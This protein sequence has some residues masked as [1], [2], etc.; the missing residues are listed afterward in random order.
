MPPDGLPPNSSAVAHTGLVPVA[1]QPAVDLGLVVLG[2]FR[3]VRG[4]PASPAPS[5][6]PAFP[7]SLWAEERRCCMHAGALEDVG[8]DLSSFVG[9]GVY[10]PTSHRPALSALRLCQFG[11]E[12]TAAEA[13]VRRR[14]LQQ[15]RLELLECVLPGR[16]RSLRVRDVG[17]D[18]VRVPLL[19]LDADPHD[20]AAHR[21]RRHHTAV[22]SWRQ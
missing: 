18:D 20:P 13:H 17:G 12:V 10:A 8:Q 22:Q 14:H 3:H 9:P 19:H 1:H 11:V 5:P 2:V 16:L 21:S 4:Q 6:A 15:E 7:A